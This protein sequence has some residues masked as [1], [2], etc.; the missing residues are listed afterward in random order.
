M[1]INLDVAIRDA[2]TELSSIE[3]RRKE[4][5]KVIRD[6]TDLKQRRMPS[7]LFSATRN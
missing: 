7:E 2:Q 6:F 4:L 5:R 3:G 1:T